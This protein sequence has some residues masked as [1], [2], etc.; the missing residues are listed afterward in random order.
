MAKHKSFP[1]PFGEPTQIDVDGLVSWGK[2]ADLCRRRPGGFT[3]RVRTATGR[4]NRGGY[5]FH[6]RASDKRFLILDYRKRVMW[7]SP[8]RKQ[9]L[10]FINHAAGRQFDEEMHLVCEEI[11]RKM[12]EPGTS[13]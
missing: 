4:P 13:Q 3:I 11:N 1:A 2:I 10:R 8:S 12:G 7:T 9:L 5:L 6:I